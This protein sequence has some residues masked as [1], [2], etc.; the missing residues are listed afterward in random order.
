MQV[1]DLRIALFSGNYN[2]VRDGANQAL[3]RLVGYLLRQG[4]AVRVYAP[5]VAEPDFVPTGDLVGVPAFA[6]PRRPEYRVPYR[7]GSRTRGD[8]DAFAPNLI[9]VSSPEL[10]GHAALGHARKR[11]LPVVASM[12]TRFETYP[13]YYGLAF[14]EPLVVALLRRFYRQC[15]AVVT[16]S[17]SMAQVM[18][19]QRMGFDIGIWTRG[20]DREIFSPSA[21]SLDWRRAQGI[22][23]HEVVIG[24]FGRLVMEK[25]LD[26]FSESIDRLVKAQVPHRVLVIGEG[27]AR[28]WFAARL[29][30]AV[31]TGFLM[32]PDLGRAVASMD[33]LFNP[34]TT[35][36]FGNVTNEVMACQIPVVAAR[37]TGSSDL[38][39]DGETG[40]LLPP[41]A[42]SEMADALIA[43]CTDATLRATHGN[44]A[45][46]ASARYDWDNVNQELVDIYLRVI[47]N[48]AR[49]LSPPRLGPP[50]LRAA[51]ID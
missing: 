39:H 41:G 30:D 27:P 50:H 12:H 38:V 16:P 28:E 40:R 47:G 46:I 25:G 20:I 4:A 33:I 21:R 13:R 17:E 2:Y 45:L 19:D 35:E 9:H 48:H 37:A 51:L 5:V 10:L 24:Y 11:N 43:Y 1:T 26:V 14:L 36:A 8:I 15:D 6:M 44:A 49:G 34:S 18:R 22:G 32:G 31:F 29:S 3:N 42:I 7:L 23:D